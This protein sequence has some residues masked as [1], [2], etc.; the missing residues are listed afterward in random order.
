[1]TDEE[2]RRM[3]IDE[4]NVLIEHAQ[5]IK[6]E[7]Q[8]QQFDPSSSKSYRKCGQLLVGAFIEPSEMDV[9]RM[10]RVRQTLAPSITNPVVTSS[11]VSQ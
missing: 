4:I 1:M 2:L 7:K 6:R 9:R 10:L 8:R 5:R 3:S 11:L